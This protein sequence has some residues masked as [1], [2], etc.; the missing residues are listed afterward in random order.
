[1]TE[2]RVR[3]PKTP[4]TTRTLSQV[5]R[6]IDN[7]GLAVTDVDRTARFYETL[8]W[9]VLDSSPR[10]ATLGAGASK[11]FVFKAV[12]GDAVARESNPFANPPG[13]D[14]VSMLVD[15]VDETYERL[16]R[17]GIEFTQPPDDTDWGARLAALHDPDGNSLFLLEWAI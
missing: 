14:H 2:W 6:G 4:Q 10:G 13:I 11:L 5:L 16:R 7:V 17:D 3:D 8:G 12:E 9:Q 1:V 15:D